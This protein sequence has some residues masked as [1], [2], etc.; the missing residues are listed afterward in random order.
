[1]IL[2]L[3]ST[4]IL[5]QEPAA[6]SPSEEAK[7]LL[8]AWAKK[9]EAVTQLGARFEQEVETPLLLEPLKSEGRLYYRRDPGCLVFALEKPNRSVVRFDAKS[10]QV[11]RPAEQRAERFLFQEGDLAGALVKVFGPSVRTL[12]S[13]FAVSGFE[14]SSGDVRIELTPRREDLKAFLARLSVTFRESPLELRTIAY[15]NAE[16]DQVSIRLEDIDRKAEIE[17]EVFSKE[18]PEGTELKVHVIEKSKGGR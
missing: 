15:R 11:H 1:M 6:G 7:A 17:K 4:L 8:D 2:V 9:Q 14:R 16:G 13:A 5:I 10:Y 3:L 12:D 18:L